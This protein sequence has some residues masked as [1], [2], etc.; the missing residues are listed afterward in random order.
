MRTLPC[1]QR[2][3]RA[4]DAHLGAR[5]LRSGR[6]ATIR[7]QANYRKAVRLTAQLGSLVATLGRLKAGGGP[8]QPDP[9]LGHAANFLYMLTRRA[10]ERPGHARLRR[11]A[12]PA[13]GSRAERVDVR[14]ARGRGDAHRHPLGHRRGHRHAEGAAA[15]RRQ[16]RRDAPAARDRRGRAARE[17]RGGRA[18]EARAQGEDSRA[19]ATACTTRE[20]PRATH[21]R[22]MSRDLGQRGGPADAGSRCRSGSRRS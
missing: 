1:G 4:A 13:R 22:Q 2:D 7:P 5:P 6:R 12:H 21:L 11:R 10:A 19:S 8:I 15:R 3:G 14:R 18:R 9:V 16:R 20:D 17:G